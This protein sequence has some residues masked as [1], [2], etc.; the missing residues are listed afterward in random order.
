MLRLGVI[1]SFLLQDIPRHGTCLVEVREA[2]KRTLV[3]GFRAYV[4]AYIATTTKRLATLLASPVAVP[5]TDAGPLRV[6]NALVCT[7]NST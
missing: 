3:L 6:I 1:S 5:A 4:S 7:H 2:F